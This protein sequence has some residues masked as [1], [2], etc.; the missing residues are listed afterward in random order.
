MRLEIV[1]DLVEQVA[2]AVAVQA[3]DRNRV[4]EPELVQLEY[5]AASGLRLGAAVPCY[6]I[7]EDA[8]ISAAYSA[9]AD[10]ARIIGG[11][12]IQSRAS[13]AGLS[14]TVKQ[15]RLGV[16]PTSRQRKRGFPSV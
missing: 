6:R 4:A 14:G 16:C 10:S 1:D 15:A 7:Y 2:R 8:K 11:W 13:I 9:L 3:G 5:G 12:Q